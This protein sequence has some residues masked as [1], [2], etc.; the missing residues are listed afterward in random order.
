[1][2]INQSQN[3]KPL[4]TW[5][6]SDTIDPVIKFRPFFLSLET[7]KQLNKTLNLKQEKCC[8]NFKI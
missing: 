8:R 7:I 1:M 6:P 3:D 4:R 5:C 2:V